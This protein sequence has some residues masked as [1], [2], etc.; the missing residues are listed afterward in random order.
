MD[1]GK[2]REFLHVI[3]TLTTGMVVTWTGLLILLS[4]VKERAVGMTLRHVRLRETSVGDRVRVTLVSM[5][6]EEEEREEGEDIREKWR[7]GK[8]KSQTARCSETMIG[9]LER[10]VHSLVTTEIFA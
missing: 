8:W 6:E 5:N 2:K 10:N 7:E 9:V 4:R 3:P 1:L